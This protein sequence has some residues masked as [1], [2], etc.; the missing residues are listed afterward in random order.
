MIMRLR[1]LQ[2]SSI[3][4]FFFESFFSLFYYYYFFFFLKTIFIVTNSF[5]C[6]RFFILFIDQILHNIHKYNFIYKMYILKQV[7]RVRKYKQNFLRHVQDSLFNVF[8]MFL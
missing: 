6:T 7:E 1:I 8:I 5:F 4:F 2:K 3:F